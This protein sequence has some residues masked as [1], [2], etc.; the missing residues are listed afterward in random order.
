MSI[1]TDLSSAPYYDDFDEEKNFYKILFRPGVAVQTREL[2]QLQTLLQNQI[3]KF[4]D[5]IYKQGTIIDGCEI[6]FHESIPYVKIKDLEADG[7]RAVVANYLNAYVKNSANLV[8]QIIEVSAGYEAREDKNTLFVNYLNSGDNLNT[9]AFSADDVLTVYNPSYPLNKVNIING[10]LGFSN[11]DTVVISPAIAI[12]NTTG[13]SEFATLPDVGDIITNTLLANAEIVAVDTTSNT[14][15]VILRVKPLNADLASPSSNTQWWTFS[16]N[17]SFTVN[18]GAAGV[19][20]GVIGTG[21]VATITTTGAG[22]V[23]NISVTS[24]GTGYNIDPTVYIKSST[25]T[26]GQIASLDLVPQTFIGR[27]VTTDATTTPVGKG[28][29]VSVNGGVI[30]QKGYFVNVNPQLL[31]VNSYSNQPNNV[32]VGFRTNETIIN[33]NIDT[34]LLDNSLGTPNA[35][36]P[37][38]DRLKLEGVLVVEEKSAVVE[39]SE[40]L[41]IIEFSEGQPYIQRKQTQY[42]II[43]NELAKRTFE[44]SGNYV[45]DPFN[46]TTRSEGTFAAEANSFLLT[47]DPGVAYINGNRVE[48]TRDYS[49]SVDKGTDTATNDVVISLSYGN[50]IR[51]KEVGGLFKFNTGDRIGLYSTAKNY[52]TL[53]PGTTPTEPTTQI[54]LA[55]IRS[56]NLESG[57]PGSPSAVYRLHLFDIDMNAG[58]NFADVRSVFYD[59]TYKAVADIVTSI[60]PSTGATIC[61]LYDSSLNSQV[62]SAGVDAIK[63]ITN[64]SYIYRTVDESLTSNT[65]GYIVFNTSTGT[66][67]YVGQL[68]TFQEKEVVVVPLA[69]GAAAANISGSIAVYSTNTAMVGTSTSFLTELEVGDWVRVANATINAVVQ[70]ASIANNTL[71][72]L[73]TNAASSISAANGVIAFP[74]YVPIAFDR[75]SRSLS[76]SANQT[77]FTAN[78]GITLAAD[79]DVSVAFNV[80]SAPTPVAK[81]VLRD[82]YARVKTSNNIGS[83]SGPWAL[84]V[85]D[86]IRLKKVYVANGAPTTLS[87]NAASANVDATND[88]IQ[89]TNH[90]FANGDALLYVGGTYVIPGLSNNT[91]YWVYG[92]NSSGFQLT[93]DNTSP[94]AINAIAT[95]DISH[96]FTGS[97]L[98]FT[99]NTFGVE[100]YTLDFYIDQNQNENYYNTSYLYQKPNATRAVTNNDV[101]LVQYDLLTH[102]ASGGM[103][104]V[105]SYPINDSL[106]LSNSA[107]TINTM[108]IPSLYTT[109]D[110]YYDLRD[111]VDFRP[112]VVSTA[113]T[114]ANTWTGWTVNPEEPSFGSRFGNTELYFP[115]PESSFTGS[116]EYYLGRIDRVVV[117]A[118]GDFNTIR[119]TADLNPVEPP[120]PQN[121][122]SLNLLKIPPYPSYPLVLSAESISFA[123]TNIANEK[124]TIQRQVDYTITT[125]FNDVDFIQEQPRV[126]TMSDIST[127]ERRIRDLEYYVAL[128]LKESKVTDRTIPS[129]IDPTINRFKYGFFVDNFQDSTYA[130]LNHPEY[131]A[132][133]LNGELIPNYEQFK[134][135]FKFNTSNN[136]INALTANGKFIALPYEEYPLIFQSLATQEPPPPPIVVANTTPVVTPPVVEVCQ[137]TISV[138]CVNRTTAWSSNATVYEDWAFTMS[139]TTSSCEIFMNCCDNDTAIVVYQSTTSS[140]SSPTIATS[141]Q[142]ATPN[143]AKTADVL[144]GGKAYLIGG[145]SRWEND[146]GFRS[147]G[148]A[149]AGG[150][151]IE[152]SY[153]MSWTHDPAKGRYYRIRV[154]K[155]GHLVSPSTDEPR[156]T[157]AFRLYYPLDGECGITPANTAPAIQP[158][159]KLTQ[160]GVAEARY[161]QY[162]TRQYTNWRGTTRTIQYKWP[163]WYT[164]D[165][166][167]L[168]PN[169]KYKIYINGEDV[170]AQSCQLLTVKTSNDK[171]AYDASTL[172]LFG[173]NG[174]GLEYLISDKNGELSFHLNVGRYTDVNTLNVNSVKN[175]LKVITAAVPTFTGS[176]TGNIFIVSS[177][178]D[179]AVV[180]STTQNIA[181]L[182]AA[183]WARVI[184]MRASTLGTTKY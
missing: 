92:A 64:G 165:S 143:I 72:T 171:L 80:K 59:G 174:T 126:Y 24:T 161:V 118:N 177:D 148:P 36:A 43:S 23:S 181:D 34:S 50:Y 13:G 6:T 33:S 17:D 3:E 15:A 63:S 30:Y 149:D 60:D 83:T 55:R 127:L 73:T 117:T 94:L 77:Q 12:Q 173:A 46:V 48:T 40:F 101:L 39:D 155:G 71:A 62:Q 138:D 22:A 38:A 86:V 54:G 74:Q 58:K 95:N 5:N 130:D 125:L 108:E 70:V 169:T 67:P 156:G 91:T 175:V 170:T 152:D 10:S 140:I 153:K 25:A 178:I 18:S 154:Y 16:A 19:I 158:P 49:V 131:N 122:I 151:W 93:S 66:F 44:E 88:F 81:S 97:P 75:A 35:V 167:S 78:L 106:T 87:I 119:G 28:Y 100:D 164:I 65:S 32:V 102:T 147:G 69:N 85:S 135:D 144:P 157:Y 1:Q 176:F 139:N 52:I 160:Q 31:I 89:Y 56:F 76:V 184:T 45:L 172:Q 41:S 57:I 115:A 79:M 133:V 104:H 111:S 26:S 137:K 61:Q 116:V 105:G 110:K 103:K 96:T 166:T 179:A 145:R 47:V 168:K 180:R 136:V 51:V 4:G 112:T 11:T 98:F 21:A 42:N 2:N 53:T 150:K 162:G 132:K 146:T 114:S 113:N 123:D 14:A 20:S 27:V 84:G 141:S 109:Q 8:G 163:M 82:R 99:P 68:T 29:G 129:T 107:S 7:S 120:E 121:S 37:G 9:Y 142:F 124:Y 128:T 182:K 90:T 134:L 159:L 183:S